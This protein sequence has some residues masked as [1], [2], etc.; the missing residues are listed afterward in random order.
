MRLKY[1]KKCM[2]QNWGG[3]DLFLENLQLI[4]AIEVFLLIRGD[5]F[6]DCRYQ[7]LMETGVME[8]LPHWMFK[9]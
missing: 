4:T 6:V 9:V 2:K 5:D 8:D 1:L 7:W 3:P